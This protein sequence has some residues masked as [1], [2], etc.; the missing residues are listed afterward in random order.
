[1]CVCL[2]GQQAGRAPG[3]APAVAAPK[4]E[5]DAAGQPRVQRSRRARKTMDFNLLNEGNTAVRPHSRQQSLS[6]APE[7]VGWQGLRR[8]LLPCV[9]QLSQLQL[10]AAHPY[11]DTCTSLAWRGL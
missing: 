2:D 9:Q 11:P 3:Q 6:R 10:G 1:M 7:A 5:L 4:E 8:P